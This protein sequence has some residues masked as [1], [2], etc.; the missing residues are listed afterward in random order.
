MALCEWIVDDSRAVP[1]KVILYTRYST[2]SNGPRWYPESINILLSTALD[3][4]TS[5]S[6]KIYSL[7]LGSSNVNKESSVILLSSVSE[8]LKVIFEV[9]H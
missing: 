5:D 9:L 1:G 7:Q 8:A 2:G 4:S 6:T 3:D